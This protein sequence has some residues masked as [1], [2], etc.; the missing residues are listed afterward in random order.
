MLS[1][2][3]TFNGTGAELVRVG[4]RLR[5]EVDQQLSVTAGIKEIHRSRMATQEQVQEALQRLQAQEAR[6][7]GLET[8][9]QVEQTR[10]AELERSTLI[11]TLGAMRQDRGG[12]NT[13]GSGQPFNLKG[14][15][16]QDFGEWTRKVRTFMLAR[17]GELDSRC[18][19][20]GSTSRKDCCQGLRVFAERPLCTLDQ[21]LWRTDRRGGPDRRHR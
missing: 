13:K 21:C 12:A 2:I 3:I 8:Q 19:N 10:T 6:I 14:I 9:L 7:A 4:F 18:S 20:S 15:A 11:Q 5:E 1:T 16:E 17:F